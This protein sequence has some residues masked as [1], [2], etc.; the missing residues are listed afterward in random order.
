MKHFKIRPARFDKALLFYIESY[1]LVC[2]IRNILQLILNFNKWHSNSRQADH[3]WSKGDKWGIFVLTKIFIVGLVR[4]DPDS[5]VSL[6]FISPRSA[7]SK[8][9]RWLYCVSNPVTFENICNWQLF[10]SLCNVYW[11]YLSYYLILR[12]VREDCHYDKITIIKLQIISFNRNNHLRDDA[13]N[14]FNQSS[15]PRTEVGFRV[16]VRLEDISLQT[17]KKD[18]ECWQRWEENTLI[19]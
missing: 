15:P 19:W 4:C 10:L 12:T 14:S 5:S 2:P 6:I 17:W 13:Q 8:Y 7:Y 1:I 3:Q 9:Q 18:S 16:G 11:F